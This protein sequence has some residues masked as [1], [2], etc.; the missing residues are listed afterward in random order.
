MLNPSVE[1]QE[2]T[3]PLV[4]SAPEIPSN[5]HEQLQPHRKLYTIMCEAYVLPRRG[6]KMDKPKPMQNNVQPSTPS[7]ITPEHKQNVF[8]MQ[9][10]SA[11]LLKQKL[12]RQMTIF[13]NFGITMKSRVMRCTGVTYKPNGARETQ[14]RLRQLAKKQG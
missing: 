9:S 8:A 5:R 11:H 14:R 4:N 2:A 12:V 6:K 3:K 1:K 7:H 13:A 10:H